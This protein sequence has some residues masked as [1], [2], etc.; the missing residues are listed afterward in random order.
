MGPRC[1]NQ[2]QPVRGSLK[3]TK[4]KKFTFQVFGDDHEV[5]SSVCSSH[6]PAGLLSSPH[7][8]RLHRPSLE[9]ILSGS[10]TTETQRPESLCHHSASPCRVITAH[11]H[12]VSSSRIITACHHAASWCPCRHRGQQVGFQVSDLSRTLTAEWLAPF[13]IAVPSW[14]R[15]RH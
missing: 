3:A 5:M 10:S 9:T 14:C 15:W 7:D 2:N 13:L 8:R 1:S 12:A 4:K 11:L 6:D